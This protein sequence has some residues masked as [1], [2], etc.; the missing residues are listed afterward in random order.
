MT[1]DNGL[2]APSGWRKSTYSSQN[3]SCVEVGRTPVGHIAVRDTTDRPGLSLSI[4]PSAWRTFL[5]GIRTH[6]AAM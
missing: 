6:R 4:P 5:S 2:A 3:G 1:P